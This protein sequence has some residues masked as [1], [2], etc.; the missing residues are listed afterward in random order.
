MKAV[1]SE[2]NLLQENSLVFA[3]C[4]LWAKHYAKMKNWN[5][6]YLSSPLKEF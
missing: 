4:P 2:T 1:D 5:K 6:Q 3:K